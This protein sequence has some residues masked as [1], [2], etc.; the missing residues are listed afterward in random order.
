MNNQNLNP[1]EERLLASLRADVESSAE[2][3]TQ[4]PE[5]PKRTARRLA[6]AGAL[7]TASAIAVWGANLGA[8]PAFAVDPTEDGGVHIQVKTTEGAE[9]LEAAL[10]RAGI[11]S[12]VTFAPEGQMCDGNV[13]ISKAEGEDY[14]YVVT[15]TGVTGNETG[16]VYFT[17]GDEWV[18]DL[19]VIVTKAE[20]AADLTY[21][22]QGWQ[23]DGMSMFVSKWVAGDV[24]ECKIV[25]IR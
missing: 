17:I 9:E 14:E 4:L 21:V 13:R 2:R 10:E 6:F 24:G 8:A 16:P 18:E 22:I 19:D 11:K 5:R 12:Q 25:P 7:A 15:D 20:L 1:F 23:V 3:V